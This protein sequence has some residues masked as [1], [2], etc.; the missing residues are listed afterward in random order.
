[1]LGHVGRS[2]AIRRRH[3]AQRLPEELLEVRALARGD[4]VERI[5]VVH[6]ER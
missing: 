1:M 6:A 3:I 2:R 5:V 4:F